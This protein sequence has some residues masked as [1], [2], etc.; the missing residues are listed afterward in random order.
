MN[1]TIQLSR[2]GLWGWLSA[3]ALAVGS[4]GPWVTVGPFSKA[5]TSGDGILTLIAAAII[6][7]GIA[8]KRLLLIAI[9]ALLSLA[10]GIYD[11]GDVSSSGNE[12]F[13]ASVGWG[14]IMVNVAA[15]SLLAWWW[16]ARRAT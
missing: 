5:G 10:V 2:S 9:F 8:R 1:D 14:L 3:G 6:A 12:L 13:S 7:V 15:V 4:I 11:V 16:Q